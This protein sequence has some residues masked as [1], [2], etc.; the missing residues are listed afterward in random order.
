MLSTN[1]EQIFLEPDDQIV[2][3]EY[4][5]EKEALMIGT[6]DGCLVL[7][8]VD[9]KTTEVV[10]RVEGGVK[11]ISASPDGAL[12]AVTAGLGQLLVMTHDWEVLYETELD[13]P[14]DVCY[15]FYPL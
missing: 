4:L 6:L 15:C 1:S 12:L 9:V 3:M 8:T 10:G 5:M 14:S 7:H 13:P 2:A 11:S